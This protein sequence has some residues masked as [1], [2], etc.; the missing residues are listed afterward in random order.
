MFSVEQKNLDKTKQFLEY[1]KENIYTNL[2]QA[3][4]HARYVEDLGHAQCLI[5]HLRFI[6]GELKEME[7]HAGIVMPEI[8]DEITDL[9][10]KV[11]QLYKGIVNGTADIKQLANN[12][13]LIR[14]EFEAIV[15]EFDTNR[16]ESIVCSITPEGH[17]EEE[18]MKVEKID[19]DILG[20][21]EL[22]KLCWEKCYK[23]LGEDAPPAEKFRFVWNCIKEGD[24]VSPELVKEMREKGYTPKAAPMCV[25]SKM[26]KEGMSKEQAEEEC[27]E[28][29]KLH[30]INVYAFLAKEKEGEI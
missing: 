10:S 9:R 23:Q 16:C 17:S 8:V 29:G 7:N 4:D 1:N 26:V 19:D 28:E 25:I 27:I 18:E 3:E 15:P 5:K 12:I 14:K 13:W 20:L 21:G 30:P 11:E 2:L 22:V 24:P 6:I